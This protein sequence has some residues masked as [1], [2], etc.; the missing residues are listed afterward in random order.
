MYPLTEIATAGLFAAA[1]LTFD[2][3]SVSVMIAPFLGLM[4]ALAII[5]LRHRIIPNRVVYPSLLAFAAYIVVVGLAG[6][7]LDVIRA[8]IGML[9]YGGV[10]LLVA[11]VSPKGMGMG[12]VKLAALIGLVLGSVGLRYVTVAGGAGVLLGGVGAIVALSAGASRKNAI[13]FGPFLAAGALVAAFLA[14][15]ISSVYLRHVI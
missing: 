13:P 3:V 9:A 2:R 6:G 1:A 8:G 14:P 7:G 10:L 12:D 11:I 15:Q 5:D 4:V